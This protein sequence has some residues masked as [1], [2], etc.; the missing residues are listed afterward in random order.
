MELKFTASWQQWSMSIC[1]RT[2]CSMSFSSAKLSSQPA[3]GWH[4]SR[5]CLIESSLKQR[6]GSS[7]VKLVDCISGFSCFGIVKVSSLAFL[8]LSFLC[9]GFDES[10][11]Y[12]LFWCWCQFS[13]HFLCC[14]V[15]KGIHQSPNMITR[16]S[17][18]QTRKIKT[19]NKTHTYTVRIQIFVKRCI[20]LSEHHEAVW[21]ISI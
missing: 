13:I 10:V 16:F 7:W 4:I 8:G 20:W 11:P 5:L 15:C 1:F 17:I 19:E 2:G 21:S 14:Q 12:T 3:L 18:P 9:L 6:T